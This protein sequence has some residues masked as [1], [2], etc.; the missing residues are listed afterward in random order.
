M[1][2]KY[3]IGDVVKE[4]MPVAIQGTIVSRSI[5]GDDDVY[6]V[7]WQNDEG[8]TVESFFTETNIELVG[9]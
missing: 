2:A 6:K 9:A 4:V 5:S 3:K 8:E 1:A 7:E